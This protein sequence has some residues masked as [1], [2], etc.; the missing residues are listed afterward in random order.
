MKTLAVTYLPRGERSRTKKLFDCFLKNSSGEVEHLDLTKDVPDFFLVDNLNAYYKRDYAGEEISEKEAGYLKKMDAMAE[1]LSGYDIL[2]MAF[3]MH[4]F[5]FPG[6]IKAFFDSV[7]L[8]GKTW[9]VGEDGYEGL[10]A[11]KKALVLYTS[12]GVYEG[13]MSSYN[14]LENLANIE[15]GFMGFNP[16]KVISAQGMN[17][18]PE[19]QEETIAKANE[20]IISLVKEWY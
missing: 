8:K 10:L 4:N 14:C 18:F 20:K 3:P 5:S 16:V 15:L 12:G 19:K 17:L 9:N 7:M 11:G 6:I 13:E 2:V 1:R